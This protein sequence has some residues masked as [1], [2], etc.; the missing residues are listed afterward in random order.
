M[1]V[2]VTVVGRV[3]DGKQ[4]GVGIHGLAALLSSPH[5][6]VHLFSQFQHHHT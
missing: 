4:H 2:N 5:R 1:H 3:R 6:A